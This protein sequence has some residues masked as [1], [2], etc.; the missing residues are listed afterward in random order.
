MGDLLD[1]VCQLVADEDHNGNEKDDPQC[2]P[3]VL[4]DYQEEENKVYRYPVHG[5]R[6]MIHNLI[7]PR[8]MHP[9]QEKEDAFIDMI[10]KTDHNIQLLTLVNSLQSIA[11][12]RFNPS[13]L[14]EEIKI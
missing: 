10:G 5:L 12:S 11:F 4:P 1:Q 6:G 2:I 14:C 8:C 13:F 9:I 3:P 7:Q